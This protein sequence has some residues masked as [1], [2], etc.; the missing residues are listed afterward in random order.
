M[1]KTLE[2]IP[3]NVV[4][5]QTEIKVPRTD[6]H[7]VGEWCEYAVVCVYRLTP[8]NVVTEWTEEQLH[9]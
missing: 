6:L 9:A 3:Q 7:T 4:T 5:E 8:Q 1:C 2:Q